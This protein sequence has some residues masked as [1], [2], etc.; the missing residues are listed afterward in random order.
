MGQ[1]NQFL[2]I[3]GVLLFASI[4]IG[5]VS[6]RFGMPLLLVFLLIGMAAGEDGPGG[7]HFDDFGG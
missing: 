5:H 3:A 7:I 6:R 1:V 4:L 2:L